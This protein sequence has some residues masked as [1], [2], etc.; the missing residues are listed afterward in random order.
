MK[1]AKIIVC[2]HKQDVMTKQAPYLPVHV[3]K[4][5]S[6]AELGIQPDDEGE[7]ISAKNRSYCELTGLYWA[8]KNLKNV[9]VIGLC[10]YRRYFDF[11]NQCDSV[12]PETPFKTEDFDKI[13]LSI[14][15]DV[16]ENLHEGEAYV[17]K[18]RY[19]RHSLY[20]DYCIAH[21]SDDIRT[22]EKYIMT[23]QTEDIREAWYEYMHRNCQL[24]HY[25]MFIMTWHDFDA[26]CSWLFPLL[27]EMEKQIDITHYT[28][29]QGRIWGYMAERLM[30]VWLLAKGFKLHERPVIWFNDYPGNASRSHLKYYRNLLR[31]KLALAIT[32][33][34]YKNFKRSWQ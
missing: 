30:N 11:H 17:A 26:Y 2:C 22:L 5:L 25:N 16:L 7:N 8:W 27:E 31:S 21:V 33:G 24:R 23:T 34:E 32:R 19:Y 14:P 15:A 6:N 28:P 29:V 10:H 13:D 9:D 3:G 18:P 1:T 12:M 4:A 20:D